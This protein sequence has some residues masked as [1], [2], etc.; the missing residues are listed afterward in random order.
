LGF[1]GCRVL[2][3]FVVGVIDVGVVVGASVVVEVGFVVGWVIFYLIVVVVV[4]DA[5]DV[6]GYLC[7]D[8]V[9]Y[10]IQHCFSCS[11]LH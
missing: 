3:V 9:L 2:V 10:W 7:S 11:Y 8:L 4:A 6:W 5:V 1:C